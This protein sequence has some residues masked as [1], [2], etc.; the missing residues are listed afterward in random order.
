MTTTITDTGVEAVRARVS[1]TLSARLG[2]H[3]ERLHWD[4][5]RLEAF[6]RDELRRLLSDAVLRSPF[7][8]ARLEG[9]DVD[10]FELE[11][12]PE[13]PVMNKEQMMSS[14]SE[15]LADRRLT[16]T[17][18]KEHLATLGTEPRL[19]DGEYVCLASG[20]SSGLRGVFV[21]RIEEYLEF[22]AGIIRRPLARA[23]A[24]G[25]PPTDGLPIGI[26]ATAAPVHSSGFGAGVATGY[27][28]R[29]IRR[30]PRFRSP[31]SP[32]GRTRHSPRR[33][34]RMPPS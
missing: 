3:T 24:S 22:V 14:F 2:A 23:I 5:A 9:I 6:Q 13:L 4:A 33:C 21:Q 25:G 11:Q 20:E 1:G 17:R 16:R 26:I 18:V 31:S 7:H 12:L 19:L 15:L 29:L 8:A 30:R 32:S 27:P 10:R 28:V 34:S